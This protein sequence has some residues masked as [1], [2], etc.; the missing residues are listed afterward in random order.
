[1]AQSLGQKIMIT[2]D[3]HALEGMVLR[4][5]ERSLC[6]LQVNCARV[7]AGLQSPDFA[8]LF[9]RQAVA[10]PLPD[11]DCRD[12]D[13]LFSTAFTN[14][15]GNFICGWVPSILPN[16]L[17][18]SLIALPAPLAVFGRK[19]FRDAANLETSVAAFCVTSTVNFIS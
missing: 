12:F 6:G 7:T 15:N 8:V 11:F 3:R 10:L 5:S 14:Q 18:D 9:W 19:D 13:Q 4:V 2:A 17:L 1:M 16:E